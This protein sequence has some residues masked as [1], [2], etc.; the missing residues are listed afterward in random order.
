MSLKVSYYPE[1]DI[2]YL[3]DG[4]PQ[5]DVV[6]VYP[7][8]NLGLAANGELGGLEIFK[9]RDLLGQVVEPLRHTDGASIPLKG[10]LADLDAQLRP[11]EG[12]PHKDYLEDW[13]EHVVEGEE[14]EKILETLRRGIADLLEQVKDGA[15]TS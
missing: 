12:S 10:S 11:S 8:F 4:R 13:P 9:A 2:L 3:S 7:C 15:A 5:P 14:A 6:E 1:L